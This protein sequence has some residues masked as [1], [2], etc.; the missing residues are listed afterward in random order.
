MLWIGVLAFFWPL[1]T[2]D[3]AGR[4]YFVPGDFWLQVLPFHTFAAHQLAAG[5]PALWDPYMFSGHPFQADI[6]TAVT[7]PIAAANEWL[8]GRGFGYLT[9][10]WEAVVHFGL[11]A[12]FTFLLVELLTGSVAG[13]LLGGVVFAFGGFLTSYPSQQ[14]PVLESTVWLPLELY[15]LERAARSKGWAASSRWVAAAGASVGLAVLAGHPQTV[16]YLAYIGAAYFLF[17]IPWRAWWQAVWAVLPAAGLGAVQLLPSLQLFAMNQKGK[18]AFSFAAG[19]LQPGDLAA[20]ALDQPNGGR[21]L[22]VGLVPLALAL[23]AIVLVRNRQVVFWA[24]VAV[25]GVLLSLGA[26]G[27][28]FRLLFDYLPGWNLFRDQERAVVWFALAVAILAGYGVSAV[29]GRLSGRWGITLAVI[30]ALSYGNLLWAN[31]GTNLT[32]TPPRLDAV[33]AL[34]QPVLADKDIFR[35]RISEDSLGHNTGN[36]EG[37]Q[38]VSGDSP[39][40]LQAFKDWTEDELGGNRVPEWQLLRLTNSHYVISS[41]E[42]CSPCADSDGVRLLASRDVPADARILESQRGASPPARRLY[43]YEVLFPLPRAF[44]FTRAQPVQNERQAVQQLNVPDFDAGK[45]LLLPAPVRATPTSDDN[46][47]LTADVTGYAPGFVDIHTTSDRLAY[48]YVSEVSYPGWQ[49]TVDGQPASL[50][51]ADGLFSALDMPPGDH[52]VVLRYVP[53]PFYIG[54]AISAATLL[55]LAI[56]WA[57]ALVRK[58]ARASARQMEATPA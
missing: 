23:T 18:L 29:A 58:H 46:A 47:R 4:E 44:F 41:R 52:H 13:G 54:A 27:P 53:K 19:G 49:A 12:M 39:F 51:V 34:L 8:G 7:Y 20:L 14:L 6:Q 40:E 32:T 50:L 42:L 17:R 16:L 43:L 30:V 24:L 10:E 28:L 26:Y 2:P 5:K 37:L 21:I 57:S 55:G 48:L 33:D 1:V 11:A 36:L 15:C 9:L 56:A 35:V 25:V 22:Y 38:F 3:Q 45:T 31:G